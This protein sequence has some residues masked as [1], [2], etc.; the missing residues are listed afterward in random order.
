M[1]VQFKKLHENAKMPI[2]VNNSD[3]CYDMYA[4]WVEK[5]DPYTYRYHTGIAVQI[6]RA[7]EPIE[8]LD[9]DRF[10]EAIAIDLRHSPILLSLDARPRSSVWKTG[11]ILTNCEGTIDE[12]YT[13]EICAVFMHLDQYKP[14]YEAGDRIMQVKIGFTLPIE[15]EEVSEFQQTGYNQQ[16]GD[17]GW[18]SSGLGRNDVEL[19]AQE[20]GEA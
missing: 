5:L 3:F 15:W 1:K 14:K 4:A 10:A 8:L 9:E 17:R 19:H 20:G 13:G 18:G 7:A 12:G 6:Q 16:R 2:K 11:M